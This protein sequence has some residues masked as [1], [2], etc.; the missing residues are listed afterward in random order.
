VVL[1]SALGIIELTLSWSHVGILLVVFEATWSQLGFVRRGTL[2][3]IRA[4]FHIINPLFEI[5]L[6]ALF[7]SPCCSNCIRSFWLLHFCLARC[8]LVGITWVS[9]IEC[10]VNSQSG[11]IGGSRDINVSNN[12]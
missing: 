11:G 7:V 4:I 5:T 8:C 3:L 2:F 1:L 12:C 9:G 10:R 6:S